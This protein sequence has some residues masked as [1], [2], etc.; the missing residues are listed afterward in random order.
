[1]NVLDFHKLRLNE[2]DKQDN[3]YYSEDKCIML[4][5]SYTRTHWDNHIDIVYV[6][7]GI[8]TTLVNIAT[9]Y[10]HKLAIDYCEWLKLHYKNNG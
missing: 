1:M 10:D 8:K 7:P 2:I 3:P 4:V 9:F 5:R 6:P